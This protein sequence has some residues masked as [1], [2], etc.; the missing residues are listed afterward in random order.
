MYLK[1][2]TV[3]DMKD[4]AVVIV[5]EESIKIAVKVLP[6]SIKFDP[7]LI[8]MLSMMRVKVKQYNQRGA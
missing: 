1:A 3:D 2:A 5:I 6:G 8:G 7:S 4:M